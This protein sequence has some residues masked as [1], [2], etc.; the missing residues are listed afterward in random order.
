M[1]LLIKYGII[2]TYESIEKIERFIIDY[3]I[4][5]IRKNSVFFI[6]L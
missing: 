5:S 1:K 6:G 2:Y 4:D 3:P